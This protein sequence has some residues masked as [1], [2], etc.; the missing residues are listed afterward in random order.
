MNLLTSKKGIIGLDRITRLLS[1]QLRKNEIH[2]TITPGTAVTTMSFSDNLIVSYNGGDI[3]NQQGE[4][5]VCQAFC[6]Q[7]KLFTNQVLYWPRHTRV[8]GFDP[9]TFGLTWGG[10]RGG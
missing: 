7:L 3:V 10:G 6:E 5:G 8:M 2:G 1:Q 4:V 9:E